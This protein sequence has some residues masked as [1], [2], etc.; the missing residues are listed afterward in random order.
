EAMERRRNENSDEK[1]VCE[2]V[3]YVVQ[4]VMVDE[5]SGRRDGLGNTC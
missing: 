3:V 5:V 2:N 1:D 4:L